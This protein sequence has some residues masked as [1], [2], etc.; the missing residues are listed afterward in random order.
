M[1][2]YYAR[3]RTLHSV[4]V[5][6]YAVS[7]KGKFFKD[8]KQTSGCLKLEVGVRIMCKWVPRNFLEWWKCSQTT[9]GNGCTVLWY[10][11]YI[12]VLGGESRI[13]NDTNVSTLPVLVEASGSLA[14]FW[15][16]LKLAK[17]I[18]NRLFKT[19]VQTYHFS[20]SRVKFEH[21]T[22]LTR[23]PPGSNI[24]QLNTQQ[25]RRV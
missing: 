11:N 3:H 14:K 25:K 7:R 4:W 5:C 17:N 1:Q 22:C 6:V 19:V 18:L 21:C 2:K 8:R 9:G 20:R 16:L 15:D 13:A 12:S 23:R 24:L 10:I